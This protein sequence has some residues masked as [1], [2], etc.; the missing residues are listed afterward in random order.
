[1]CNKFYVLFWVNFGKYNRSKLNT[2]AGFHLIYPK[3]CK[4]IQ[5][6]ENIW[7]KNPLPLSLPS[8]S[9]KCRVGQGVKTPPFHGGITG[10]NPVR[11]TKK[12]SQKLRGFFI[13]QKKKCDAIHII[14]PKKNSV[15]PATEFFRIPQ[16]YKASN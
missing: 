5:L 6:F 3:N 13:G 16:A 11:G 2:V 12:A 10:S 7:L 14:F 8:L 1:M 9:K 4:L 15:T